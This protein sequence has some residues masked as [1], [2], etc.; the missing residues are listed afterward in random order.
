[1]FREIVSPSYRRNYDPHHILSIARYSPN[2]TPK[3]Q[4]LGTGQNGAS[5]LMA[6]WDVSL[7]SGRGVRRD[8]LLTAAGKPELFD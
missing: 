7:C 5:K 6:V 8:A 2:S 3:K 4:D 1:M